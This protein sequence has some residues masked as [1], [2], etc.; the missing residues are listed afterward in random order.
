MRWGQPHPRPSTA[1]AT[2]ITIGARVE[3]VTMSL[4]TDDAPAIFLRRENMLRHL[5]S[6]PT[7]RK[8]VQAKPAVAAKPSTTT[9]SI[10]QSN[11]PCTRMR[12]SSASMKSD[13][14]FSH[15][16]G[17]GV[18]PGVRPR[19]YVNDIARLHFATTETGSAI[20]IFAVLPLMTMEDASQRR[21]P[22]PPALPARPTRSR[23]PAPAR[24]GSPPSQ[25][26]S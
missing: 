7:I 23:P 4:C 12:L 22:R 19:K 8:T 1:L 20:A 5:Y 14:G 9:N 6:P 15:S 18:G 11:A 24:T 26:Q 2:P 16:G 13:M 21:T 10:A 25:R 3:E 17:G